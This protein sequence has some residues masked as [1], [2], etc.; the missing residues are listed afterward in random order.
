MSSSLNSTLYQ[1]GI[2]LGTITA[3]QV[4]PISQS[5]PFPL[6]TVT[7]L[8]APHWKSIMAHD[9]ALGCR[10]I[11]YVTP[12]GEEVEAEAPRCYPCTF[13]RIYKPRGPQ[14]HVMEITPQSSPA[15]LR[16]INKLR[17]ITGFTDS[18]TGVL[19]RNC[20]EQRLHS[21]KK[22]NRW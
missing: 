10:S 8:P 18:E 6:Y 12:G 21:R 19:S 7:C 4:S 3:V 17:K 15:F 1:C 22:Y 2:R 16:N 9:T 14:S 11:Q 13:S 20:R 5:L